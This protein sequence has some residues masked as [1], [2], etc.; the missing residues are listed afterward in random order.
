MTKTQ[1]KKYLG[2]QESVYC[3][4]YFQ[5]TDLVMSSSATPGMSNIQLNHIKYLQLHC[6]LLYLTLKSGQVKNKENHNEHPE[7]R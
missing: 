3:N 2:A 7:K 5:G 4:I 6:L 1:I